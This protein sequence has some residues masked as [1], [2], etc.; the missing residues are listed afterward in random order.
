RNREVR[1]LWESQGIP[2]NRLIRVRY[3]P[4]ILERSL[5][6]GRWRELEP[7]EVGALL[8]AVGIKEEPRPEA[9]PRRPGRH[10]PRRR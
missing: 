7:D 4:L 1:R 10:P 2:V 3:G 9:I 5:P 6:R 8:A